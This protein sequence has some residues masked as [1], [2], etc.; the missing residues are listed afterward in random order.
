MFITPHVGVRQRPTYQNQIESNQVCKD[1]GSKFSWN[2]R[3]KY[4]TKQVIDL[5]PEKMK[6]NFVTCKSVFWIEF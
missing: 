2:I 4:C 5:P 6:K 3:I 1:Y